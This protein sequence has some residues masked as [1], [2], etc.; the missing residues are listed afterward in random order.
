MLKSLP[1]Q[2]KPKVDILEA[3]E[4]YCRQPRIKGGLEGPTAKRWRPVVDRFAD[5]IGHRDLARVTAQDTVRWRD[6]ML[7]Q[8]IAP[9]AVRDVWLAAPRAVASHMLNAQKLE[10]NPFGGIKVEGVKAWKEDDERA[11]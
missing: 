11:R 3:F 7:S 1:K 2:T 5:W 6:H 4:L 8:G 10:T 9:K